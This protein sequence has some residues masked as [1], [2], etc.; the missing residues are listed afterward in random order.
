M[1][2]V[3]KQ[4]QITG[5]KFRLSIPSGISETATTNGVSHAP[6]YDDAGFLQEEPESSFASPPAPPAPLVPAID[7]DALHI[8]AASLLDD[9]STRA[10]AVIDDARSRAKTLIAEAVRSAQSVR[11]SAL[12][13]GRSAG[14]AEGT[15]AAERS[16]DDMLQT[17]RK[18]IEMSQIERRKVVESA[19]PELIRLAMEIAERII[20]Q[21]VA[22]DP[23]VV[24]EMTK[25]AIGRLVDKETVS[26]RV[27]PADLERVRGH[28]DEILSLTDVKHMHVVDDQ[29]VDRGGV[30]VET[31]G[32]TIDARVH[33]QVKEARRILHIDDDDDIEI[34]PH[35]DTFAAHP[36]AS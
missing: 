35:P 26:V 6:T 34:H 20:H 7:W 10:I 11:D 21:Q 3:V 17:M 1:G 22:L 25:A 14:M 28:R 36:Q 15:A 30:V 12:A 24:I 19:E 32:G 2:R 13:D 23:N 31:D 5:S 18:I 27:N 8:E 33:T 4:G 16:M 29:R 9:A